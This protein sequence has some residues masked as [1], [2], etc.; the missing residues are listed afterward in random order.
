MG[1]FALDIEAAEF[2]EKAINTVT[3]RLHNTVGSLGLDL[4][5]GGGSVVEILVEELPTVSTTTEQ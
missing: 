2:S 3:N 5:I 4:E 1:R